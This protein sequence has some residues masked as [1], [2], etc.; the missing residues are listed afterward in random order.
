[1]GGSVLAP[2]VVG[3][4]EQQ[5]QVGTYQKRLERKIFEYVHARVRASVHTLLLMQQRSNRSKLDT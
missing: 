3:F 5:A 2:A 1:M 4:T